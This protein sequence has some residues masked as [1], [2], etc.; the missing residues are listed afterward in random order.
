MLFVPWIGCHLGGCSLR[1]VV[2][3]DVHCVVEVV[4][5]WLQPDGEG[6]AD[7]RFALY[8]HGGF[9]QVHDLLDEG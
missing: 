5:A 4:D 8:A 6:G 7:I 3:D 2:D 1:S 9:V